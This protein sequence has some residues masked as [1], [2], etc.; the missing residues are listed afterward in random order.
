M[1]ERRNAQGVFG[2]FDCAGDEGDQ[3]VFVNHALSLA[4]SSALR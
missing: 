2:F 4:L 3:F 1:M